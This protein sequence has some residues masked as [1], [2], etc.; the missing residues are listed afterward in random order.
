MK[1][2]NFSAEPINNPKNHS[3]YYKDSIN[4]ISI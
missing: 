2:S 1:L 3:T 4:Y